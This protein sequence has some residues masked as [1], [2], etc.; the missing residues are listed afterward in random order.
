MN[1][2]EIILITHADSDNGFAIAR[3]LLAAG[4]GVV[5]TA[6][7]PVALSRI[8]LGQSADRVIAIAADF[9]DDAQ[10]DDLLC[11][12]RAKFGAPVTRTIDGRD[13]Q[14]LSPVALRIA[15]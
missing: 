9:D 15:S 10:R 13:P 4:H 14:A 8:L 11:S 7:H 3:R 2:D 12:A 1:T 5:V 6:H